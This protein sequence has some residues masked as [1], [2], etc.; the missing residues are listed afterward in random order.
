MIARCWR[1]TAAD[2]GARRYAEHFRTSVLPQLRRLDGFRRADLLTRAV[3]GHTEIEVITVWESMAAVTAF[4]GEAVERAV[5]EH[6]AR[7]VLLDHDQ[8]V[9]HFRLAEFTA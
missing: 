8:T 4:A 2:D 6:A 1:A 3:D 5:V 7:A 9:R